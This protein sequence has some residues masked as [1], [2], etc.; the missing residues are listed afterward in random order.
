MELIVL[1][2][3]LTV[4]ITL[5]NWPVDT[6]GPFAESLIRKGFLVNRPTAIQ[7]MQV[8]TGPF[9]SKGTTTALGIEYGARRIP[10]QI[11]NNI[12]SPHENV[13]E[14]LSALTTIGYPPQESIERIDIQGAVTI[15]TQGDNAS[16]FASKVVDEKFIRN[17]GNIFE[18][19][20]KAVGLR[21]VTEESIAAGAGGSPFIMLLEPLFNDPTDTKLWV[22]FNHATNTSDKA[23]D[24]LQHLYDRLK[25]VILE[26]KGV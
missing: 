25:K 11:T 5:Q 1:N 12:T 23:I 16:T 2:S 22:Q 21:L 20:V 9:A 8:Q 15:K 13:N 14:V 3:N 17:V 24:F 7:Q 19:N 18:R 26:L 6:L 4:V 10:M